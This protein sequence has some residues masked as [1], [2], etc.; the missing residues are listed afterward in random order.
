MNQVILIGRLCKDPEIREGNGKRI[1]SYTL[2]VDRINEGADFIQCK[3]W[4][5]G[6][7][8]A[9][10]YLKKGMKIAVNGRI[11]TGSYTN[12]DGQ[13]VYTTNVIVNNHEFC[14]KK[15]NSSLDEFMSVLDDMEGLPF[16]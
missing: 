14:E 2:A 15:S 10:K 11:Q 16:N 9:E 13:T 6:A 4:E 7:D 5:K 1:A 12:K 8:F 3:T